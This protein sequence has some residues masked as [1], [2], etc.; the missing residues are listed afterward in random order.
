MNGSPAA[1]RRVYRFRDLS[2]AGVPYTRKHIT[3]LE[4]RG[5]FP[6]HFQLGANS[7]AW[8]A[9]EVDQWV[10]ERIRRRPVIV[11]HGAPASP[12]PTA[13]TAG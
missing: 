8:V 12:Q 5:E 9:E 3:A 11:A 4:K 13:Q 1:K 2:S 10:E 7:V 6:M